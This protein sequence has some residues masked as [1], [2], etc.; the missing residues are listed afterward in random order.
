MNAPLEEQKGAHIGQQKQ[1]DRAHDAR[2]NKQQSSKWQQVGQ[3]CRDNSSLIVAIFTVVIAIVGIIQAGIYFNQ[4]K[5][6]RMDE[7]A[8]I[9]VVVDH[10][11]LDPGLSAT[12]RIINSGRTV[13]TNVTYDYILSTRHKPGEVEA[14]MLQL[15][16]LMTKG[17]VSISTPGFPVTMTLPPGM[18]DESA[19]QAIRDG[20]KP[21]CFFGTIHYFDVFN[22]KHST[23]S[24]AYYSPVDDGKPADCPDWNSAD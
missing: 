18:I 12:V 11:K 3:W 13:A 16:P 4:L 7:R 17:S 23:H 2:D 1:T 21:L 10:F 24:C 19:K 20:S 22:R 5:V 9:T 14:Y 6:M 15:P 8:W